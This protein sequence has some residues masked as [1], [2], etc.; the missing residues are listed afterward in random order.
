[1][2]PPPTSLLSGRPWPGVGLFYKIGLWLTRRR[3]SRSVVTTLAI[4]MAVGLAVGV[5]FGLGYLCLGGSVNPNDLFDPAGN[6]AW[7]LGMG[8]AVQAVG[9]WVFHR[10]ANAAVDRLVAQECSRQ[11]APAGDAAAE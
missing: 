1:M 5:A 2:A 8:L 6:G 9:I 11:S 10:W 3:N 4:Y 7:L